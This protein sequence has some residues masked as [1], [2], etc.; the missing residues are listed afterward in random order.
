M[1]RE[2]TESPCETLSAA[3]S[4]MLRMTLSEF[5]TFEPRTAAEKTAQTLARKSIRGDVRAF[6]SLFNAVDRTDRIALCEEN[7]D[8]LSESLRQL[9]ETL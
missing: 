1:P 9:A 7:V 4:M 3:V 2:E 8:A 5:D 6:D